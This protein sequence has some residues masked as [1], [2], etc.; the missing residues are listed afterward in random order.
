MPQVGGLTWIGVRPARGAAMEVRAEVELVA[1]RGLTGDRATGGARGVSLIQEEHLDVL[2]RLLGRDGPIDP[3][4]TRRNLVVAGV[5]LRAL[6]RARFRIGA[7]LLEGTGECHP[8]SK[9]ERALGDGGYAAMRGHGGI[10]A[11]VVEGGTIRL[12]DPVRI[13]PGAD[14]GSGE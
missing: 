1:G 8:C 5:N 13:A 7:C 3:A 6:A 9:M 11:R 10:L 12:G 2:A 14:R 4:L